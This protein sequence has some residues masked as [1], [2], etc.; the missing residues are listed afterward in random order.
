MYIAKK[1]EP[2]KQRINI[3]K[4]EKITI[5]QQKKKNKRGNY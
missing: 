2:K 3:E 5:I 1:Y 4:I